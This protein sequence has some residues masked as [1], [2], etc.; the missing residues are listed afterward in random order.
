MRG[1]LWLAVACGLLPAA[2]DAA[3]EATPRRIKIAVTEIRPL[4]TE[5]A[6]ADLL[7]E[8]ALTEAAQSR[9]LE[10]VGKSD[11][12]AVLGLEQQKKVLGCADDS[13]CLA[14][15]GGALGVDYLLVGTL[16]RLGTLYR[17]DLKLVDARK[18]RALE[19][20]GESV[21][22]EE[23]KLVGA[24][25]RGV[26]QLIEPLTGGA[27][28][29]PQPAR[30]ETFPF[31][32]SWSVVIECPGDGAS[33]RGYKRELTAT[34][35]QGRLLA[36]SGAEG[37]VNALRSEGRIGADGTAMLQA[38]GRTGDPAFALKRAPPGTPYRYRVRAEFQGNAGSGRRLEHRACSFA[39]TRR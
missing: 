20:F 10:V 13:A 5:Q 24:V 9:R 37:E 29:A 14:E 25:Q 4:N 19:R 32:G 8:V 6:K 18:A 1:A 23:E 21:S 3:P 11:I 7:S 16:G 35:T 30:A 31:D 15:I 39:F 26:R 22:G 27:P 17:I 2:V 34:V 28:A 36:T 33:V 38:R 12:A